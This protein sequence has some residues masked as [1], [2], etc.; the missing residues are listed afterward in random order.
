MRK[1]LIKCDFLSPLTS[2]HML[3]QMGF[4]WPLAKHWVHKRL[5]I[6]SSAL[7]AANDNRELV[8]TSFCGCKIKA[9]AP[10]VTTSSCFMSDLVSQSCFPPIS[11]LVFASL[12]CLNVYIPSAHPSASTILLDHCKKN[13]SIQL[14]LCYK[15]GKANEPCLWNPS[16]CLQ[17]CSGLGMPLTLKHR[18]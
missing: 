15:E 8:L 5:E 10:Q 11:A 7:N 3:K 2:Y 6:K 13:P 9:I 18:R 17:K 1:A 14:C 12:A 4:L 16:L